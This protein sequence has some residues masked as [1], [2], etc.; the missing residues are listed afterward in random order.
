MK[1][2]FV[3]LLE[4]SLHCQTISLKNFGRYNIQLVILLVCATVENQFLI[5]V[6]I[7]IAVFCNN[8]NGLWLTFMHSAF[9]IKEK[10]E[11]IETLKL[12][13]ADFEQKYH[14]SL[15]VYYFQLPISY[16]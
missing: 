15:Q 6:I 10:A 4:D 13:L 8:Q 2:K 11:E 7:V 1:S 3:P 5:H 16:T 14:D 9:R 12:K